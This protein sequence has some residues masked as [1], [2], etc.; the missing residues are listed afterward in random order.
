[1]MKNYI[2][3]CIHLK[4]VTYIGKKMEHYL[5]QHLKIKRGCLLSVVIT[6]AIMM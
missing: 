5:L 6:E 1:M 4:N 2:V 3:Q